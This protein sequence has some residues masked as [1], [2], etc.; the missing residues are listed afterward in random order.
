MT[1]VHIESIYIDGFKNV[2]KNSKWQPLAMVT[3]Q[4]LRK[5]AKNAFTAAKYLMLEKQCKTEFLTCYYDI[6]KQ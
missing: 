6:I 1:C 2:K 3:D 5:G 4:N